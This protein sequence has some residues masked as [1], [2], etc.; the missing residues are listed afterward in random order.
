MNFPFDENC[1]I[2]SGKKPVFVLSENHRVYRAENPNRKEA[3]SFQIDGAMIKEETVKCDKGLLV[4]DGKFFLVE[5]KGVDVEHACRQL[6]ATYEYMHKLYN[7]YDYY[8]RAI[9]SAMP[10][11]KA[12]PKLLGAAYRKLQKKL[13]A[14]D[15]NRKIV[16]KS[17]RLDE[18]I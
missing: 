1:I 15:K 6:L 10:S 16:Y 3:S 11:K 17:I 13:S 7:D 14:T 8:C 12:A 9:V 4:E 2:E 5:L 18:I